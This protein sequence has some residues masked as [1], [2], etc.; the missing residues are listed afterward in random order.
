MLFLCFFSQK[1]NTC[2]PL[3]ALIRFKE[4][5]KKIRSYQIPKYAY[6]IKYIQIPI[7]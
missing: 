4:E 3:L 2:N 6:L 1:S 5:E 7:A